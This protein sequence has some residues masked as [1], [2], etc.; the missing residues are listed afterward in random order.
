MSVVCT[1]VL[2]FCFLQV[3]NAVRDVQRKFG[4]GE[5]CPKYVLADAHGSIDKAATTVF[6]TA[7]R[8][9]CY[10]HVVHAIT[11]NLSKLPNK[12]LE[13]GRVMG[14]IGSLQ[15]APTPAIFWQAARRLLEFWR[16]PQRQ[17]TEFAVYFREYWLRRQ[18][19]W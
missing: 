17:L 12:L 11:P 9:V 4:H 5:Y 15:K 18:P 13:S 7:K 6:P 1:G 3:F 14:E 19:N 10:F 16:S 8:L 2:M